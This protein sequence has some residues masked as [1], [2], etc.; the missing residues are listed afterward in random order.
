MD[1]QRPP[2]PRK[3]IKRVAVYA[4]GV[5]ALL[6][7][8]LG[9]ARLEPAAPG[10]DRS[11]IWI[12]TVKRG[13][14]V[15]EVRGS[16][17]LVP[18]DIRWISA[19][20]LGKVERILLRPGRT[21]QADEVILEL[22]NPQLQQE[23]QDTEFKLSAAEAS[24]KNLRAQLDNEYLQM[25][26]SAAGI[27]AEYRKALL[28]ADVNEQ[29]AKQH[30]VS[31]FT[32]RQS[33]LD[34][35]QLTIRNDIAKKQ[36][37]SNRESMPARIAVQQ[38]DVDQAK[39]I[40]ALKRRQA[41]DMQ[42]RAGFPGVL[43]IVPVE[44]G[45]QVSPGTNLARVANPSL[46]KAEVKISETQAK[47]IQIG[48]KA[49]VDTRNG[50]V[51]GRVVRVDPSVQNG[52]VTVD[53]ALDGPLPKGARPDLSVDGTIELE[54]LSDV[55]YV[56]VPAIAQEQSLTNLF[57]VG[58]DGIATRVQVKLG[59]ASVSAIE[60]LDGLNAGDQVILSDTS[61]VGGYDRIRLQ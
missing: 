45:Q 61:A 10:V 1:F 5:I 56:G 53:I 28:Q 2:D 47:D 54:R 27:E 17:T 35:D 26:A 32:M 58:S 31:D 9:L 52:T 15:R 19:T 23:L 4:G 42:V 41:A 6:V 43:Q 44:V 49:S 40:V 13:P 14:M 55:L 24:L 11:T 12:D 33:R 34:A 18:E 25:Q 8:V 39:A 57:R 60:V 29:M 21:V 16:G 51:V 37:V 22:S 46:L 38:S 3:K 36:L 50:I 59:R 20:T 48:Q 7:V 30:L